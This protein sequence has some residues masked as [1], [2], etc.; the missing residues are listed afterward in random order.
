MDKPKRKDGVDGERISYSPEE[1]ARMLGVSRSTIYKYM[2]A[3]VLPY[4]KLGKR[5]LI[6]HEDLVSLV[7]RS[8]AYHAGDDRL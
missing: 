5:R 6:L 4:S 1:A 7:K 8:A 2:N 3:G